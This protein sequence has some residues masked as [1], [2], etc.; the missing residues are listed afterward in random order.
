MQFD[1]VIELVK[2]GGLPAF[3][4]Y[5]WWFERAERMKERDKNEALARESISATVKMESALNTL[6]AIFSSAGQRP[7]P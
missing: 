1:Q 5:L 7:A 6:N 4:L 2:T 3:L